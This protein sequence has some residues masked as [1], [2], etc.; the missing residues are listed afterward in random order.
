MSSVG[1]IDEIEVSPIYVKRGVPEFKATYGIQ[2][3][4]G[5]DLDNEI[6]NRILFFQEN[7]KNIFSIK[8]P[9]SI[10][11]SAHA[12]QNSIEN[13]F[14]ILLS[15]HLGA[16]IIIL[17]PS[18]FHNICKYYD[19]DILERN[20]SDV[21]LSWG[22]GSAKRCKDEYIIG[23]FYSSGKEG[24]GIKNIEGAI[25]PQIPMHKN[26]RAQSKYYGLSHD[27][28]QEGDSRNRLINNVHKLVEQS[29]NIEFRAK[30]CDYKY[31]LNLFKKINVNNNIV[32]GDINNHQYFDQYVKTHV[33]YF[34]T[35]IPES[36][37]KGEGSEVMISFGREDVDL[38]DK[39][40]DE[41][42]SS[43]D[44]RNGKIDDKFIKKYCIKVSPN[45]AAEKLED[46][47]KR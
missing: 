13:L 4:I 31:Y 28:F 41:F 46:I 32:F 16:K 12:V 18:F 29:P 35:A 22:A 26:I 33:M 23:S 45:D 38:K 27:I 40:S 9:K 11:T 5:I 2:K 30:S 39:I 21:Y 14:Y 25:L 44:Q 17:Q 1:I 10:L 36:L 42:W 8:P 7:I 19:Q 47:L 24:S 34:G 6:I 15:K 43:V 37:Y 3:E 20:I